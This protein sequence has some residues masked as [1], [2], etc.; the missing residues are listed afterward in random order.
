MELRG[1][2]EELDFVF[3]ISGGGFAMTGSMKKE[4]SVSEAPGK[5][6]KRAAS[7]L[8]FEG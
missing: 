1:L 8:S 6:P 2:G 4:A 5:A 3:G 7:E